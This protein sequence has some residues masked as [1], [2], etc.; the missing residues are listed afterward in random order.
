[1]VFFT[2]AFRL[3]EPKDMFSFSN[4]T[5][6]AHMRAS[7][8]RILFGCSIAMKL[9]RK[10]A[11]GH[12]MVEAKGKKLR[13]ITHRFLTLNHSLWHIEQARLARLHVCQIKIRL[14]ANM[15]VCANL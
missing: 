3:I 7:K 5:K 14:H 4:W 9:G 10:L 13:Q 11:I 6:D 2:Q 8:R 12:V 15:T 1:M